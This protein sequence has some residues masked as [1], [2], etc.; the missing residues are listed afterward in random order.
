MGINNKNYNTSGAINNTPNIGNE[1]SSSSKSLNLGK[2]FAYMFVALAITM[3]IAL[4]FGWI[5]ANWITTSSDK[6]ST[7]NAI[8]IIMIVASFA[9]IIM[10]FVMNYKVLK[11]G[12]GV[13]ACFFIYAGLMG[14]T[15]STLCVWVPWMII[16][17]AFGITS[18]VFLL[19]WGIA[20]LGKEKVTPLGAAGAGIL[21]GAGIAA[22]ISW[23]VILCNPGIDTTVVWVIDFIIFGAVM[24]ITI[25]DMYR[26]QSIAK[27]GEVSDNLA[28]YCACTLYVDFIYIFVRIVTYLVIAYARNR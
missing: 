10:M 26:I 18:V 1:D 17:V 21:L 11:S 7:A 6:S 22:L 28:V 13:K 4:L 9:A 20:A 23:I 5:F 25:A 2:I 27:S 12:K 16:G 3:G 19:M 24:L 14:F 8:N 15:L